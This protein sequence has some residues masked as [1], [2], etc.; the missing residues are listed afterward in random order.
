MRVGIYF[1]VIRLIRECSVAESPDGENR[2]MV[3]PTEMAPSPVYAGY[4][5]PSVY[6]WEDPHHDLFPLDVL[7]AYD[8]MMAVF[9]QRALGIVKLGSILGVSRSS[10]VYGIAD[11]GEQWTVKYT[12]YCPDDF[13]GSPDGFTDPIDRETYFLRLVNEQA[14]AIAFRHLFSSGSVT[15]PDE[16]GKLRDVYVHCF[17]E[18]AK[19]RYMITERMTISLYQVLGIQEKIRLRAAALYTLNTVRLLKQLHGLNIVH[20]DIHLANILLDFAPLHQVLIDFERSTFGPKYA[21]EISVKDNPPSAQS[22]RCHPF[23]SVWEVRRERVSFRDDI[24]RAIQ[25]FAIMVHGEEYCDRMYQMCNDRSHGE[26]L[27]H[28]YRIKSE[29]NIFDLRMKVHR[30]DGELDEPEFLISQVPEVN[31]GNELV[32]RKMLEEL[33]QNVRAPES[34][35]EKPNYAVIEQQL[36]ELTQVSM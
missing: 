8:P 24:F 3:E 2:A 31:P 11:F 7:G 27:Q 29:M 33:L 10:V 4:P 20:G 17:G 13:S 35:F 14:P 36:L 15:Q 26:Q 19:V 16:F 9:P 18:A 25:M 23:L 6:L 28:F 22:L 5:G 12:A 32:V 1:G 30:M 34:P 21:D